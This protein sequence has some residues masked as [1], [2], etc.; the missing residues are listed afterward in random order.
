MSPASAPNGLLRPPRLEPG[1]CVGI[2]APASPPPD[3]KAVDRALEQVERLGFKPHLSRHVRVRQGFLAGT[4]RER[5]A[6]LMSLFTNRRVRGIVCLRGGYGT[7]RL[8]DRL[9][10]AL[11]RRNPK[12]FAGYSDI[13]L[14]HC[15]LA[16]RAKLVTFHAPMLNEGLGGARFPAFSNASFLRNV[17]VAA[18]SGSIRSG[19]DGNTVSIVRRGVAEGRLVGGNLSVLTTALGTPFQPR[20]RDAIL[21]IEDIGEKPYRLDRLLTHLLNAGL[22][23]QVAG[24]AVGTFQDCEDPGAEKAAEYR[25]T[26]ADVLKE[27]LQPLGVP[28]VTG[29]PFGHQPL[30]ATL[31]LGLRAR[32]DAN[33]GDL[34]ITEA[35]VK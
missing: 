10:Y 11:I 22:L 2:A 6:D 15:L 34:I 28:V 29:L 26:V 8:V 17:C 20:F 16:A 9:D 33:R 19:E 23:A 5:A 21:A 1:D 24:V 7:A 25:Q 32:L 35:A 31:P 4:D 3:P 14:L 13:T 30:N 27:R 12:V 18:P